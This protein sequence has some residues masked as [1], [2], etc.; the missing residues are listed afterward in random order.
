MAG[1]WPVILQLGLFTCLHVHAEFG[2]KE[3]ML[4]PLADAPPPNPLTDEL[5]TLLKFWHKVAEEVGITYSITYGTYLGWVRNRDYIPYDGDL[6]VHIGSDGVPLLMAP[7]GMFW[8]RMRRWITMGG[9]RR[10]LQQTS[11]R[12]L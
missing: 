4:K 2:D 5:D 12:R 6:D 10:S 9:A 8:L 3:G 7:R 11:W 1:R